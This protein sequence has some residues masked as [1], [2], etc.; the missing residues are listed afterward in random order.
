MRADPIVV[1]FPFIGDEVGGSHISA[2]RLIEALNPSQVRPIVVLHVADGPVAAYVKQR[3]IPFVEAPLRARPGANGRGLRAIGP[4]LGALA[5]LTRFLRQ[6]G[7]AI[8]HTNDGRCHAIWALPARLAGAR[9][10]WH[11]RGDPDAR[12]ANW[13]APLLAG[14]IV[15]VSHFS[16][17]ERPVRGVGHK[18]SVVHSPFD[19][20]TDAGDRAGARA[21]LIAEL[22]CPSDTAF[23]GYFGLL[24]DRKRPLGFVEAVAAFVDRHPEIPVMG[25]LFGVPGREAPRLGEAVLGRASALGIEGRIRLMGYRQPVEPWMQAMDILLVPAVREPFGRTLIEAMFLGTPVVATRDGGNPEAIE[26]DVNGILV[27]LEQPEAFVEP[28]F[29]LLT[30]PDHRRRIVETA[31][32]RAHATYNVETHVAR[33]TAI[34]QALCRRAPET[35]PGAVRRTIP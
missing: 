6:H 10:L 3:G 7:V 13:L 15:T 22:G 5:P 9:Q 33:L 35:S 12:G 18:L 31:R 28:I 2:I 24:I 11:H 1:C 17:P 30:D 26:H 29:R 20:P 23:L 19:P 25:L 34:Y 8:V 27:P 16:R 14:H 4:A 21:R 32:A